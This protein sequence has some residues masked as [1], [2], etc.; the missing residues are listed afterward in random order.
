[1][2]L[3]R[4]KKKDMNQVLYLAN[5]YAAFDGTTTGADLAITESFPE[6]FWVAEKTGQIVGFAYGHFKDIPSEVL[7]R[8]NATK[9]AE[10]TLITVDPAF[11]NQGIGTALLQQLLHTFK[12]A[13][14]DLIT[15]ACPSEAQ[16]AKHLYDKL[17]FETRAYYMKKRL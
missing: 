17:G 4:Y 7:T 2:D 8:W 3:R 12:A 16:V 1:M 13:G 6:G 14:A 11:R 10:I 9:V 15:L 5:T